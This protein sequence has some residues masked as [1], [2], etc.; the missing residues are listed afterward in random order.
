LASFPRNGPDTARS[1]NAF[2]LARAEIGRTI[3]GTRP[4]VFT[5]IGWVGDRTKMQEIGRPMSGVGAGASLLDGLIRFD[6][7]RGLYPRKQWR[8]DLYVEAIF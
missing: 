5:D 2:W 4:V 3:Q 8:V 1:G 7:A 6:I